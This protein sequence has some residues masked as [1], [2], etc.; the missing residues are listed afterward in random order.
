MDLDVP[1][2]YNYVPSFYR[3]G[4]GMLL[5]EISTYQQSSNLIKE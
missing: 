3:V 1:V 5:I 4:N 2:S